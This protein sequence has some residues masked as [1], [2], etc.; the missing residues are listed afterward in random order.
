[1]SQL[2]KEDRKLKFLYYLKD[3]IKKH[4]TRHLFYYQATITDSKN[5]IS[6]IHKFQKQNANFLLGSQNFQLLKER[7]EDRFKAISL[8]EK[9]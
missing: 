6:N 7:N 9:S 1:M 8:L 3:L 4:R 5:S 2:Q